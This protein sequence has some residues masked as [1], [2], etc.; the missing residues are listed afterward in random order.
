MSLKSAS[1]ELGINYSSAKTIIKTYRTQGRIHKKLTRERCKPS[2]D[3]EGVPGLTTGPKSS[4]AK[5]IFRTVKVK[6][7]EVPSGPTSAV[8]QYD[9]QSGQPP[10]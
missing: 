9:P 2:M 8:G 10:Q 7:T 4:K 3:A 5:R 6:L 1:K